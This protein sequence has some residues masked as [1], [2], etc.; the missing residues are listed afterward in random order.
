MNKVK[1]VEKKSAP[2][3]KVKYL[4]EV[5]PELKSTFKLRNDME[6]PR[7]VKIVV[8]VGIGK[9]GSNENSVKH[10]LADLEKVTGQKPILTLAKK[11]I[12]GFKLKE[13][14]KVGVKV[15]LRGR[16]MWDFI[17][18]LTVATL[19]RIKDFQG[20]PVKNFG[21]TGNLSL[22]L[23]EHFVFPEINP[24][25]TD[26]IFGLQVCIVTTAKN[27]EQGAFLLK[28]LGFPL[29]LTSNQ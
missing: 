24:D 13:K 14:D 17:E 1:T 22:G 25:E 3:L 28:K 29:N 4:K 26:F 23:K 2:N 11:A 7:L 27:Q 6:S 12:A 16:R 5:L 10:I 21:G 15:T 19:P 20:V 8:N 9:I 18:R